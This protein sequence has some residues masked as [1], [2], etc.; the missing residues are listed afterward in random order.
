MDAL[1]TWM[2]CR[3]N[4]L[5]DQTLGDSIDAVEELLRKHKDFEKTVDAQS[6]KFDMIKR[7]TLVR[8]LSLYFCLPDNYLQLIVHV[9]NLCPI[10]LYHLF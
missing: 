1:E 5:S 2:N 10:Y 3:E 6:E 7:Q 4:I 9:Y 8:I